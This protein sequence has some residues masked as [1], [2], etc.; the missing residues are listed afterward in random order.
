MKLIQSK[1]ETEFKQRQ[2]Q[3][4]ESHAFNPSTMGLETGVIWLGAES[5]KGGGDR[6]SLQFEDAF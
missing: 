5:N 2:S 6:S 3:N 4:L 1:R